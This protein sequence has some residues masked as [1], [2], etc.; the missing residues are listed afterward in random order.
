M[1]RKKGKNQYLIPYLISSHP[2]SELKHAIELAEFLRD[3]KFIPDQVQ[4]FYPTPGTIST[5]MFYTGYH[6]ITGKN[7]SVPKDPQE[8][9]MQRA[10]IHYNRPENYRLVKKAL[11]LEG[12]ADLIGSGKKCLIKPY[13]SRKGKSSR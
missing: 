8:K 3:Y 12:R 9:A 13:E 1:N 4:D 10:L 2:G 11:Q 6:P 5:C 7:I